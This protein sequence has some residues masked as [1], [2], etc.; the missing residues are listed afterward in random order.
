MSAHPTPVVIEKPVINSPFAEPE[1]HFKFDENG[2]TNEIIPSRRQSEY[3]IPIPV[4]KGLR[5]NPDQGV[6][7]FG[8]G[9]N[10]NRLQENHFINRVRERVA[11][12]RRG[13]YHG[14]TPITRQLLEHWNDP[15]R[16]KR[17]FFCQ[18]EAVETAIYITEVAKKD[19]AAWI[20]NQIRDANAE[21]N[22]LLFR[23]AFKM[24]TGAG[25]TV[26]MAMLIAWHTLNKVANRQDKKFSDAFLIVTPGITIRDRLNVLNPNERENYYDE[27]DIVPLDRRDEL[28]QANIVITNYHAFLPRKTRKVPKVTANVLKAEPDAFKETPERMVNRVL[29]KLGG[30]K[31]IIVFNDEAHHCYR[32]KQSN[33]KI[34]GGDNDEKEEMNDNNKRARVWISGIEAVKQKYGIKAVYDLS[35]TPFFLKGSGYSQHTE[36]GAYITEGVLFP[37]VVSDF[38][39]I[40]AIESGI[41]KVPRVPVDDSLPFDPQPVNRVLWHHIK[42]KLPK[43]NSK[44]TSD[45]ALPQELEVALRTLYRNY[46]KYYQQWEPNLKHTPPPVMIIVCN[47]IRVSALVR[48]W[49]SG[50]EKKLPGGSEIVQPGRLPL[51][52]NEKDGE[53]LARPNTIL[54]HSR[55][56]ESG[57]QL[58]GAFKKVAATEIEQFKKDYKSRN[59][60]K[61]PEMIKD[62][63]LLREVMNT[64]GKPGKI[65][66]Q[67][68]CVIS[69]SMLTEGWDAN[70]VTHILGI[71]AFSTQL[72][73]EQVVGR[74]LRRTNYDRLVPLHINPELETFPPQFAEVYGI[75]FSFIPSAGSPKPQKPVPP[76]THVRALQQRIEWEIT[77][78]RLSG[79]RHPFHEDKLKAEFGDAASYEVQ[80]IADYTTTSSIMGDEQ[81]DSLALECKRVQEVD[82]MIAREILTT[83]YPDNIYL[84]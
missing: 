38:S 61:D 74:G 3:F 64:V 29:R 22:P 5:T 79:Y 55:E 68:K 66:E 50:Y 60:S 71:R 65:G 59:P 52:S 8:D 76:P 10:V 84:F 39:L 18:I 43:A 24:A 25:K 81:I 56:T 62:G 13:G 45:D 30:K 83:Y 46:E 37:W 77:F 73:C 47:N 34:K 63:E 54:I 23:I 12:W 40:D 72:L 75:P 26:V 36:D 33:E 16:E 78:P 14:I 41:V 80:S 69:V 21:A 57:E 70:T 31:S 19:S 42:D 51:F 1:R 6:F 82:Y 11:A 35:A 53:W 7:D 67:I 28:A 2:I 9:W 27:R 49:V 17:L 15:D 32:P 20:E 4:P 58:G 44:K 48:D